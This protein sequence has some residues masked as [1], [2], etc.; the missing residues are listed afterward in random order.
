MLSR[1]QP[2]RLQATKEKEVSR[3]RTLPDPDHLPALD[4]RLFACMPSVGLDDPLGHPPRILLLYGSLRERSFSRFAVEEAARN[5]IS[6]GRFKAYSAGNHPTGEVNPR[7]L[8][9]LERHGISTEG[10]HSKSWDD[11]KDTKF[12]LVVTVC[13]NAAGEVCP[14]FPGAP[15]KVHWG[16]PDPAHFEGTPE[17]TEQEFERVFS[18]LKAPLD[19]LSRLPVE[20]KA[21]LTAKI[22]A[23]EV[24]HDAA[25][26]ARRI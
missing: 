23:I 19:E 7:S 24:N 26:P 13:D 16:V 22:K 5:H 3:L 25:I 20:G 18:M 9:T 11:L 1:K 12:D 14:F 15:M 2:V 4:E 10:L 8:E 6:G 17:Q 21:T